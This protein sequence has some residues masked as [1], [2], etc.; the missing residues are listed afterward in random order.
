MSIHLILSTLLAAS[1]VWAHPT[2]ETHTIQPRVYATSI[3]ANNIALT[4]VGTPVFSTEPSGP[5]A[6]FIHPTTDFPRCL[7]A[8]S[9]TDGAAVEIADCN[10]KGLPSQTWTVSGP[11]VQVFGNMCLD[12]TGGSAAN[13]T[14]LQIWT[15]TEGDTNQFWTLSDSIIRWEASC[16]DLTD[17][18]A[19]DG[20][21]MQIWV[22]TGGSNQQW[23]FTDFPTLSTNQLIHPIDN[24]AKCL[25]AA[26]NADGTAVEINDCISGGS[27]SQSWI[28]SSSITIFGDMCLDVTGGAA[29][30]GTPMQIYTCSEEQTNQLW[31]LSGSTI[32]WSGTSSCLDLTNGSVTDGNVIQIWACTGGPNQQWTFETGPTLAPPPPFGTPAT[33]QYIHSTG[34]AAKCLT[35]ASNTDGA[36]VEIEDCVSGGSASQNWTIPESDLTLQIFGDKCLDVTGGAAANGTPLQIWTCTEGNTNQFWSLSESMIRWEASCLDLTD[37]SATDGNVMQI[38]TCT[39]GPNQQ[40]TLTTGPAALV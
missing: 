22:C 7:T 31:T 6:V 2:S 14:P 8:A 10:P 12:V 30:D 5:T 39:G 24:A 27:A 29:A 11:S 3:H 35:A 25:T 34:D 20:N 28:V 16:L 23:R 32:Q 33:N 40:W 15:C 9:N 13:G 1:A 21:V 38:W 26:S 19:M 36:A 37:G 17:G 18:S 4:S